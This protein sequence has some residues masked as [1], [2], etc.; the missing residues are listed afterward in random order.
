MST[1]S[2]PAGGDLNG[3]YP[4][5]GVTGLAAVIAESAA[6]A[7]GLSDT[8]LDVVALQGQVSTLIDEVNTLDSEVTSLQTA[9]TTLQ[10]LTANAATLDISGTVGIT[11]D[12]GTI[13]VVASWTSGVPVGQL[14]ISNLGFGSF[15]IAST[16]GGVDS[17]LNVDYIAF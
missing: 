9:V 4:N 7:G 16:A 13:A 11:L 10:R 12:G 3:T 5:P 14:V 8:Q 15:Q 17:G 1:P 2:G 6:T